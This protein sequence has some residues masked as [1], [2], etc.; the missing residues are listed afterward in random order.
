MND[1]DAKIDLTKAPGLAQIEESLMSQRGR[2]IM[3]LGNF[4]CY[5]CGRASYY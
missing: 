2:R 1:V 3:G 4:G 5:V